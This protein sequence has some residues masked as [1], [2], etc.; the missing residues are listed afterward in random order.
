VR[1]P[2]GLA[3]ALVALLTI[4]IGGWTTPRGRRW[5]ARLRR[6]RWLT[7]E[8]AIPLIWLAIFLCGTVSALLTWQAGPGTRATWGLM[9]LYWLVDLA[10]ALYTPITCN[11]RS[12]LAG[13]LVGATGTLLGAILTVL[14]W[15]VSRPAALLLLPYL[16]WSPIGTYVTWE[17][18]KL[19][20]GN[21]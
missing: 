11:F 17:M 6:P 18:A 9:G 2:A 19:N 4:Q 21:A 8:G 13:T 5:F 14:V 20:P 1:L 16:L 7:F 12:L 3:I 10:I 15:P